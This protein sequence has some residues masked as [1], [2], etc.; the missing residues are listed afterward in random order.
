MRLVG[1]GKRLR[2]EPTDLYWKYVKKPS[3]T[4]RNRGVKKTYHETGEHGD[5]FDGR[6][7]R[8]LGFHRDGVRSVTAA[9]GGR[10]AYIYDIRAR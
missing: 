4:V 2:T 3:E 1:K 10:R 9:N 7:F 5:F 8:G 6:H